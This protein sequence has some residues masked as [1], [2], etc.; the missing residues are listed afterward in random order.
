METRATATVGVQLRTLLAGVKRG[1]KAQ[2]SLPVFA[3]R[4]RR[5]PESLFPAAADSVK[6]SQSVEKKARETESARGLRAALAVSPFRGETREPTESRRATPLP[7]KPGRGRRAL[8]RRCPPCW[9]PGIEP[10]AH[11]PGC[12]FSGTGPRARFFGG[13]SPPCPL[14][15][16]A[17]LR[18]GGED[19][20]PHL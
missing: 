7:A 8:S 15:G 19:T 11:T 2:E 13:G 20:L 3:C 9:R 12:W 5:K 6:S 10:R 16:T 4:A 1:R 14:C 18:G 17:R